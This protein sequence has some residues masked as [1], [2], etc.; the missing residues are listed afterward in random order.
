MVFRCFVLLFF[1]MIE[2]TSCFGDL[3]KKLEM[4]PSPIQNK[5]EKIEAPVKKEKDPFEAKIPP[6]AS[7][8]VKGQ[9]GEKKS[10]GKGKVD[11]VLF[12]GDHLIGDKSSGFLELKKNVVVKRTD[13]LMKAESSKIFFDDKLAE[14]ARVFAEGHVS[15]KKTDKDSNKV[16]T[17][18]SDSAEY[19]SHED[20][21]I[22]KGHAEVHRGSDIVRGN[23]I[24]YNLK[25]GWIEAEKVS[26]R[27]ES[28]ENR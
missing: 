3:L 27:V 17:T 25:T 23:T 2:A 21:V 15:I 4:N 11:P 18:L 20:L 5:S 1:L 10:A 19:F 22:L 16:V 14:V 24:K 8:G 7:N 13:F 6:S 28:K 26:G 12:F 9:S